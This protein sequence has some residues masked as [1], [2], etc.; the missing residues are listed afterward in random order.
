MILK[1]SLPK[2]VVYLASLGN[3]RGIFLRE[4][5]P[6]MASSEHFLIS[7]DSSTT[8]PSS[9]PNAVD[10]QKRLIRKHRKVQ[11][12]MSSSRGVKVVFLLLIALQ[13]AGCGR[14]H[15]PE[16]QAETPMKSNTPAMTVRTKLKA[17]SITYTALGDSTGAGVGAID[18]GYVLRLFKRLRRERPESTLVNLC[19]SG[20]TSADVL[21]SQL[22]RAINSNPQLV[23]V[24]V[25]I[26]DIGH[27][28][29]LD[30]FNKNFDEILSRLKNET[31]AVIVVSN[32][33][34]VSASRRVPVTMRP[35]SQQTIIRFNN[36]IQKL[37]TKHGVIVTDVFT[38]TRDELPKHPEYF[39]SDGFHPSDKGYELWAE[40]MWGTVGKLV[41]PG[42]E[43]AA[44][45][46]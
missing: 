20:S 24:G 36:E 40:E 13:L 38:A 41:G 45:S 29:T 12:S 8:L 19:V 1:T 7:A 35:Q 32:L 26:N 5:H 31:S 16:T 18:G 25:G 6:Q 9:C 10:K 15:F 4:A 28:V 21:H 39:S 27:G 42:M 37:A 34:D 11:E 46:P 17:G 22:S 2:F 30:E 14:A 33:P 44:A 43:Q 23:T 3:C